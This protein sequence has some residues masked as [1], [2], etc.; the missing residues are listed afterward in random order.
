MVNAVLST[1]II[2]DGKFKS[3]Q[4][5]GHLYEVISPTI[6]QESYKDFFCVPA[7]GVDA[8]LLS[9]SCEIQK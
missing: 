3:V 6:E 5:R 1:V 2:D 7:H 9:V 8:G 4:Q